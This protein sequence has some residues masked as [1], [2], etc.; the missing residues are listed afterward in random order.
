MN[1]EKL[2]I[3]VFIDFDNIQIG[4]RS[5][6]SRD[7]DLALVLEALKERGEVVTKIA[8][9]NWKRAGELTRTLTQ[10]AVL[11]V[12]RDLTPRGDKNGADINL[13]LDA[14]E[15]AINHPHINAFVIVGG[16]SDFI[17][18][19]E[20]LKQYNKAVF[21]VGGRSFTSSVLQRNCREFLAYENLVEASPAG[22]RREEGARRR[23]VFPLT[24][25][26]PLVYRGLKVLAD[27]EVQAQ[28]G[29]LKST[30]IQLDST[31]NERDFGAS[32][33]RAFIQKMADA[34][35]LTLRQQGNS[36]L[37]EPLEREPG[38][39]A[40]DAQ[41]S[42]EASGEGSGEAGGYANGE[43]G[44]FN[45]EAAYANPEAGEGVGE[46]R[47]EARR[48]AAGEAGSDGG[49]PYPP[50][51]PPYAP[52]PPPVATRPPEEAL[53]LLQ[54]I[55]APLKGT[56]PRPLYLR[57]VKQLL[58][59][60]APSFDEQQHG[61]AS[62]VDL[63]RA[64]QSQNWLRLQRDRRGALRVFIPPSGGAA[65]EAG[66][67]TGTSAD[68][69]EEGT[70]ADAAT[71]AG[72]R[73]DYGVPAASGAEDE[74]RQPVFADA[75]APRTPAAAPPTGAPEPEDSQIALLGYYDGIHGE[76]SDE[77]E[78]SL[79]AAVADSGGRKKRGSRKPKSDGGAPAR[80]RKPGPKR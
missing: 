24:R 1:E 75:P 51:Y 48:E 56:N 12:Q 7:F 64:G 29:L 10:N 18:L 42:N 2:K 72:N 46:S 21:V 61:F 31:F 54:Q 70:R 11:M 16:D 5:T 8:Y 27:R 49:R 57:N 58:R 26:V 22:R 45:S 63:L 69:S 74:D 25:A 40:A 68:P 9:G 33:F 20:K 14:L 55:L 13:A 34:Q 80:R 4:V 38:A 28:L 50:A 43:A 52:P 6:L 73:G 67:E 23:E 59:T 32:S 66:P 3:A 60:A 62:L 17:A 65:P 53:D 44:D 19:V 39:D 36:S 78:L 30:L 77:A 76:K 71:A 37:V 79:A 15:M 41:A 47:G 35:L